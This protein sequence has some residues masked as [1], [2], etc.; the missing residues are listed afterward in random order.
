MGREQNADRTVSCAPPPSG[1]RI[2]DDH[3]AV[4]LAWGPRLGI[5]Y[6]IA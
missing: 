3:V 2:A 6:T 4:A 5:I 1:R